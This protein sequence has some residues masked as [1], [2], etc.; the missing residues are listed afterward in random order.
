MT[1]LAHSSRIA[2]GMIT[3]GLTIE[4]FAQIIPADGVPPSQRTGL[5][6]GQIVDAATGAPVPE[7]ICAPVDAEVRG[8]PADNAERPRDVGH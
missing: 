6:I 4:G 2:S 3:L 5:I 1:G 7:A 8:E